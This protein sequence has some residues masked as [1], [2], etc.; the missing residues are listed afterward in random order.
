MHAIGLG[1]EASRLEFNGLAYAEAEWAVWERGAGSAAIRFSGSL[2]QA[3]PRQ[4]EQRVSV[5]VDAGVLLPRGHA[6][7]Q[8]A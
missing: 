3:R 7:R 2:L 1:P 8:W 4:R 5:C 6:Y